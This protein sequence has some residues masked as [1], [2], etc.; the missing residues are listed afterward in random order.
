MTMLAFQQ[1]T[2]HFTIPGTAETPPAY[3]VGQDDAGHWLAV[4][5]HGLGG[6]IFASEAAAIRFARDETDRRPGAVAAS[7]G[8]L[9]LG[10]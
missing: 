6:G 5:T 4:E 2:V 8:R 10:L 3:L 9:T 7:P 1:D